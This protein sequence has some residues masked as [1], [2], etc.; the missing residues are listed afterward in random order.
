MLMEIRTQSQ[1]LTKLALSTNSLETS[2]QHALAQRGSSSRYDTGTLHELVR[3]QMR[4]L[5]VDGC[6]N[7]QKLALNFLRNIPINPE[8]LRLET[9]SSSTYVANPHG[10]LNFLLERLGKSVETPQRAGMPR[11]LVI[12]NKTNP[13]GLQNLSKFI[14]SEKPPSTWS[15]SH[16]SFSYRCFIC[17][18]DREDN[19]AK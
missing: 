8:S 2:L 9:Q 13:S 5:L 10:S 4:T 19:Y 12:E 16:P 14:P 7:E 15:P 1:L 6:N 11:K 3:K 17:Q 18:C